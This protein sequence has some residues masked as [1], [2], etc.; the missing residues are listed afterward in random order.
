MS[1]QTAPEKLVT[2]LQEENLHLKRAVEELSVINDLARAISASLQPQEIIETIIRRSLRAV[3]GEQGVITLVE[4]T[5]GDGMKTLVRATLSSSQHEQFHCN[6]ALLGWMHLNKSPL[7]MKDVHTDSR[8]QG[9][10]WDASIHS[11]VC[12]PLMIKSALK[13]VLTVYNHKPQ[14]GFTA[15]DQRLLAIIASQSAQV[16]ENAR[17][18]ERE[19]QLVK[20]QQEVKLAARIQAGLLPKSAPLTP[21]YDI[22]GKSTAAEVVGGDYFDFIPVEGSK[23]AIC[24]GDASGKGLPASLLMATTQATLRGLALLG[25]P[26]GEAV[27]RANSLVYQSTDP[28]KFVTLFYSILDPG[29]HSL[30]YANAGHD[31]PY[32]ISGPSDLRRLSAGGVPLGMLEDFQYQEEVLPL[33]PDDVLVICSDG[34]AEAMN[35]G[36][37]LFGDDRLREVLLR[38]RKGRADEIV[39]EILTA[40]RGHATGVPQAD[41]IT[42]VV[43]KRTP[44]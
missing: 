1:A 3:N 27:R 39:E 29:A 11:L 25:Q 7:L 40:V 19:K 13:G 17:L 24:L 8:F 15:D 38:K 42:I 32:L 22:A 28:E 35:R 33:A 6:Q 2:Q 31:H 20:M 44:S 18:N 10:K 14:G 5:S 12:V 37:E 9:V 26:T 4:E 41:D 43:V 16:I 21:G 34:V 23:I 30:R 36:G